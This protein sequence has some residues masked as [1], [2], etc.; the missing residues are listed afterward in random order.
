MQPKPLPHMSAAVGHVS[1]AEIIIYL[2]LWSIDCVSVSWFRFWWDSSWKEF[3]WF[4]FF[5]DFPFVGRAENASRA[6]I[7]ERPTATRPKYNFRIIIIIGGDGGGD[8]GRRRSCGM[9]TSIII[10]CI[11][12]VLIFIRLPV[13]FDTLH[14]S[15]GLYYVRGAHANRT[16][17]GL[18]FLFDHNSIF[19]FNN[20]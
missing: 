15:H 11:F 14:T 6:Y 17:S 12:G 8:W 20:K 5:F 16:D 7:W 1:R 3:I 18:R 2:F 19:T 9:Y 4:N 13:W 10:N